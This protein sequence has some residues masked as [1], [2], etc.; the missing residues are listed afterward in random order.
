MKSL[1]TLGNELYSAKTSIPF[2]GKRRIWYLIAVVVI[3]AV[4]ARVRGRR[5]PAETTDADA[6]SNPSEGSVPSGSSSSS[7]TTS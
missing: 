6:A 7:T 4:I 2:V 3:G 5:R 1:A